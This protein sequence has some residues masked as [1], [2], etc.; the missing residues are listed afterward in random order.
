MRLVAGQTSLTKRTGTYACLRAGFL[1]MQ[2]LRPGALPCLDPCDLAKT[3]PIFFKPGVRGGVAPGL[4]ARSV[5]HDNGDVLRSAWHREWQGR[6][7]PA[8]SAGEEPCLISGEQDRYIAT[9]C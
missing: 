3:G 9:I 4:R 5:R 1:A 2:G 8:G 6:R 7:Q